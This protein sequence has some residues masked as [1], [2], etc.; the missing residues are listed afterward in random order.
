MGEAY[1]QTWR[2]L[3]IDQ[4]FPDAPFVTFESFSAEEEADACANAGVDTL[5]IT[6]K[7]HW[8]YSYYDTK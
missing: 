3:M 1:K 2:A 4:H 5:H 6:T 7:C 8:G